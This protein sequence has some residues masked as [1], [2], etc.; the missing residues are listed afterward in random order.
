MRTLVA[1]EQ[2]S[3]SE[4]Q[5]RE[6]AQVLLGMVNKMGLLAGDIKEVHRQPTSQVL[7]VPRPLE[8]L[9]P[10][11]GRPNHPPILCSALRP[12]T[13]SHPL[14]LPRQS[15]I[16]GAWPT[17]DPASISILSRYPSASQA[18]PPVRKKSVRFNSKK[19][20]QEANGQEHKDWVV[21]NEGKTRRKKQ[22][23]D[24]KRI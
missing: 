20:V 23:P 19:D 4:G 18:E 6:M 12:P 15:T 21:D 7:S 17:S 2:D 13:T 9:Q 3:K 22:R 5:V 16:S 11:S 14:A 1:I 8:H 10:H 24:K